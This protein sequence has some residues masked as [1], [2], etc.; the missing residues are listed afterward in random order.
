MAVL[1]V[2]GYSM[3]A[4]GITRYRQ[5]V[6]VLD[7]RS[8]SIHRPV[9]LG[10]LTSGLVALEAAIAAV[11]VRFWSRQPEAAQTSSTSGLASVARQ[12]G[13]VAAHCDCGGL[14]TLVT[15]ACH[16]AAETS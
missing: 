6:T 1:L 2:V 7:W 3:T 4:M 15:L 16:P 13:P 11:I 8:L 10:R 9:S 14:L 12:G 5:L